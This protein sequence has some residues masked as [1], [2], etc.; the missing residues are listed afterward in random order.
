[1]TDRLHALAD[2]VIRLRPLGVSDAEAQVA[3]E[4]EKILSWLSGE[5]ST[6]KDK[7]PTSR[8]RPGPG[9][10]GILCSISG[11]PGWT[12]EPWS[13][14]WHPDRPELPHTGAGELTY[15]LYSPWRGLGLAT[16]AVRLATVLAIEVFQPALLVIRVHPENTGSAAVATR[17]GFTLSHHTTDANDGQG[18]LDWYV[19]C[20]TPVDT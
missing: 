18:D 4:D 16:R 9:H 2:G 11:L 10:N 19:R 14:R 20:P 12:T 7:G 13:D 5:R 17:C 1:M 6:V 8:E 15:G 3:G